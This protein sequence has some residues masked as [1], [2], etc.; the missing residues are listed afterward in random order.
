MP[1]D[2]VVE[3]LDVVED[4]SS[5][6]IAGLVVLAMHR[7]LLARRPEALHR[8]IALLGSWQFSRRLIDAFMPTCSSRA[9]Y[10]PLAYWLPRSL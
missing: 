2:R 10:S 6:L 8:R 9:R 5:G 1:S 3:A 7:L 4:V